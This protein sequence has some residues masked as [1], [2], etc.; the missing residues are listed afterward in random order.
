[1]SHDGGLVGPCPIGA[2]DSSYKL[3]FWAVT[4]SLKRRTERR[5]L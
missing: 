2:D 1:M 3:H 5:Q 4:E